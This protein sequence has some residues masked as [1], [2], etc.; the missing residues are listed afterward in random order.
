MKVGSM[1]V[2]AGVAA[3]LVA[4]PVHAQDLPAAEKAHD[5]GEY[6][7]ERKMLEPLAEAGDPIAQLHLGD[8]YFYGQGGPVDMDKAMA[9][10]RRLAEQNDGF[11]QYE[12][13]KMYF[14]GWGSPVDYEKAYFWI[15]LAGQTRIGPAP[16]DKATLLGGSKRRLTVE[17]LAAIDKDVA[18]WREKHP[19][20]PNLR[21]P[22]LDPD[23]QPFP[24][25]GRPDV[26]DSPGSRK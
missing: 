21:A 4:A 5:R 17:Q 18:A 11:G 20:P 23:A 13:A 10:F 6:A 19:L 7:T 1:L 16:F 8:L 3:A 15:S 24:G 12:L 9:W 25:V 2:L 22:P 26:F 14:W